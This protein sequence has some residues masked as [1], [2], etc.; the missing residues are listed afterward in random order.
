M[1]NEELYQAIKVRVDDALNDRDFSG[2]RLAQLF[3]ELDKSLS[4][5]GSLPKPW[6]WTTDD[7]KV[8]HIY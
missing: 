5:G 7:R 1:T 8:T 2:I 6:Q 3:N 4:K